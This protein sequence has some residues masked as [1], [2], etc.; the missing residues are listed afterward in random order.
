[1]LY[2]N[3]ELAD[4]IIDGGEICFECGYCDWEYDYKYGGTSST[5]PPFTPRGPC[6]YMG[7]DY[8]NGDACGHCDYLESIGA[9]VN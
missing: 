3:L 1:M 6:E 7:G 9:R 5:S 8:C 2:E 4:C